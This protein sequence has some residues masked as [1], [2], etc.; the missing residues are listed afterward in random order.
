MVMTTDAAPEGGPELIERWLRP[1]E[2]TAKTLG[3]R[4]IA[5]PFDTTKPYA[6]FS[7]DLEAV[8]KRRLLADARLVGWHYVIASQGQAEGT[9]EVA[10]RRDPDRL[11]YA[12][13]FSREETEEV[14]KV[15]SRAEKV[16]GD[17]RM[18]LLR[19]PVIQLR[20]I[21]LQ[22]A[23]APE[24]DR[25]LPIRPWPSPMRAWVRDLR[26]KGELDGE[27]DVW[28]ENEILDLLVPEAER[29]VGVSDRARR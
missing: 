1:P 3:F 15:I 6:V 19:A 26:K 25:L 11:V 20:A 23:N 21:W 9:G 28:T 22:S 29:R 10:Q 4:S 17:F 18:R 2:L 7:S 12:G 5:G 16:D 14:L 24:N 8:L 13:L 27:K